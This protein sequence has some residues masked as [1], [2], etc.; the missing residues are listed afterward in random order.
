M[1]ASLLQAR[2]QRTNSSSSSRRRD[3]RFHRGLPLVSVPVLSTTSVSTFSSV[4]SASALRINTPACAPRPVPTMIAIGVASPSA[5]GHAI[6]S[7]ATAFTNPCARRGCR[8]KRSPHD[9]RQHRNPDHRRNEPPRDAIG[10]PLNR[11]AAA[12]RLA[13]HLH[14]LR[15]QRLAAHALGLHDERSGA[16]HRRRRS[17]GCPP[18]S[19]PESTRP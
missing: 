13:H 19:P 1:L 9:E 11:S 16:V 17:R 4:S 18:P 15:Q 10:Q 14:N 5:Q 8:P 7:T 12:L 2:H 6:I 3:H